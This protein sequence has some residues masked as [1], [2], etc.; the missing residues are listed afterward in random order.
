MSELW[1]Q[2][3]DTG[4]PA[5]IPWNRLD[6]DSDHGVAVL[7]GWPALPKQQP[8]QTWEWDGG[9]WVQVDDMGPMAGLMVFMSDRHACLAYTTGVAAGRTWER[10]SGAW[11]QVG[12]TG[13]TSVGCL[14]YYVARSRGVAVAAKSTGPVETWEWDGTA[15]TA[16]A[17]SGPPTRQNFGLTYD[18]QNKVSVLFGGLV[19]SSQTT[20]G[21]TWTW[22][23]SRWKQASDMGPLARMSPALTYDDHHNRSLLFGGS[24]G[25]TFFADTWEWDGLHWRQIS[26]M[27]PAPR[28]G[29][30]LCY[31]HQ[32]QRVVLFAG[33][34]SA[35]QTFGD[36]WE[37]FDHT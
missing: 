17:D 18:A 33:A 9:S 2:R 20:L 36:T 12:D 10:K 1:T 3:E 13:P 21:D 37:Y 5:Q 32:R 25:T 14:A 8:A 22:D 4:P 26:D 6:Y 11:T 16:V 15:W 28:S 35:T 19:S 24:A 27:G 34:A 23:G 31:D 7:L 30:G 29:A